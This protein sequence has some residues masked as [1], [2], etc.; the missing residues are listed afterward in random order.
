M[1]AGCLVVPLLFAGAHA[2]VSPTR[3]P[4]ARPLTARTIQ[5]VPDSCGP[6]CV[7]RR[8]W[9]HPVQL[10]ARLVVSALAEDGA[11]P[12]APEPPLQAETLLFLIGA[13]ALWGTYPT[14]VKLLY[15]A[16]PTLDPSV[17]VLLRFLIMAAVS[18]S[19]LL[20]TTPKFTLLR[21]YKVAQAASMPWEEQLERRVPSSVY[22]AAF[23]LGVLGGLGTFFQT[24]SLSQIPAL[25]AAVLY[26]TVNVITPALAAVAGANPTERSVSARTWAGCLLGLIASCWSLIPDSVLLPTELPTS[27]GQGEAVMLAASCC[28]AATKVRLSSHLRY[29]SADEMAVGRL[30]AQAGCALTLILT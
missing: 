3:R 18:V 15:T 24:L 30:V 5:K 7:A 16:G 17:V 1:S 6:P 14:C 12:K 26:S 23:E 22:L 25:T 13:A 29:H 19:A 9:A 2:F 10:R 20:G 28:Y 27:M 8:R 11:T 21:R 4:L